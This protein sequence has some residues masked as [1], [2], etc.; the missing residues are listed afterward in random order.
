MAESPVS[1]SKP[2]AGGQVIDTVMLVHPAVRRFAP[3][4]RRTDDSLKV[5][6]AHRSALLGVTSRRDRVSVACRGT[7]GAAV[8]G[9]SIAQ[10]KIDQFVGVCRF[11]V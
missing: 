1:A 6:I 11:D 10:S 4:A 8:I 5:S 9:R 3:G 2:L 7:W